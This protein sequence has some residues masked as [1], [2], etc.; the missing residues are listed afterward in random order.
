[1][2]LQ[3]STYLSKN[4]ISLKHRLQIGQQPLA[5]KAS[6]VQNVLKQW[7]T[8]KHTRQ[9][10]VLKHRTENRAPSHHPSTAG[11]PK[12]DLQPLLQG[13]SAHKAQLLHGCPLALN[14]QNLCCQETL[15][16]QFSICAKF[17]QLHQGSFNF[18]EQSANFIICMYLHTLFFFFGILSDVYILQKML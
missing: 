15:S 4:K 13:H 8:A 10:I 6:S 18:F 12:S 1:M 3:L 2:S 16:Q 14:L 5:V 11:Q 9:P 17:F 7:S